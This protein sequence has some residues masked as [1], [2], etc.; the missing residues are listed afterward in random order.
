MSVSRENPSRR[1]RELVSIYFGM[2]AAD[3]DIFAGRSLREHLP[4]IRSLVQATGAK[5]LL[6]Y[7]AGKGLLYGLRD[8]AVPGVGSIPSVKEYLGVEE[9]VFHDPCVPAFS[10][11]PAERRFD[12]V[13]ST[14]AI[15]HIPSS[16]MRWVVE[17]IFSSASR[18]VFGV[19][20]SFPAIKAL[21]TGEDAT[22]AWNPTDGET[23]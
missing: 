22:R 6:D 12:G 20:A 2:H 8:I 11:F 3:P 19:V 17:E 13:I 18:F 9:V 10:A 5:R 1:Y 23:I 14:D 7:G 21:P 16:D 15:E 4:A